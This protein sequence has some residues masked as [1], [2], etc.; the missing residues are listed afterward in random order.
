MALNDK[1]GKCVECDAD[2][3]AGEGAK[4]ETCNE[5]VCKRHVTG[6]GQCLTCVDKEDDAAEYDGLEEDDDEDELHRAW[7]RGEDFDDDDDDEE[8][9]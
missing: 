2:V 3:K 8:D 7:G 6:A 1:A 5:V 4:C 9:D